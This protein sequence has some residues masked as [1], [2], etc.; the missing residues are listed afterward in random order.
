MYC[1]SV[2]VETPNCVSKTLKTPSIK[3]AV[4]PEPQPRNARNAGWTLGIGLWEEGRKAH[5]RGS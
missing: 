5:S 2:R 4:D 3:K 1:K